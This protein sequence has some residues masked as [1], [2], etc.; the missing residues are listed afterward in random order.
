[1]RYFAKVY[2]GSVMLIV[3]VHF[4]KRRSPVYPLVV[5]LW[6]ECAKLPP[7]FIGG[8]NDK[9]DVKMNYTSPQSKTGLR[10]WSDS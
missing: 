9:F 10:A 3:Q 4:S 6:G 7:G 1:M 8:L 2:L 5:A